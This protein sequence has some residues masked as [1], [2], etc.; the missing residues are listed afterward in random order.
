MKDKFRQAATTPTVTEVPSTE[1]SEI[2]RKFRDVFSSIQDG[3]EDEQ[4]WQDALA[5]VFS[6]IPLDDLEDVTNDLKSEL[7]ENGG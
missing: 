5:T 3:K 6:G 2:T 4:L 7:T 1:Q